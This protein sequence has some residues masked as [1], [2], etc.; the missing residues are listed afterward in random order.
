MVANFE[1]LCKL[2]V[3]NFLKL[4]V[5][6]PLGFAVGFPQTAKALAI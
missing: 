6:L 4:R 2:C 1:S 3:K 5:N